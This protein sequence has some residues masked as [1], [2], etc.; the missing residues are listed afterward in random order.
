MFAFIII[1]S[2]SLVSLGR[3]LD[4]AVATEGVGVVL[5]ENLVGGL[6]PLSVHG[7]TKTLREVSDGAENDTGSSNNTD[8]A[9]GNLLALTLGV[10]GLTGTPRTVGDVPSS[11]LLVG[12]K[13]VPGTLLSL[14]KLRDD[15]FLLLG[16]HLLPT[17][18]KVDDCRVGDGVS[19]ANIGSGSG[20]DLAGWSD[21]GS[22]HLQEKTVSINKIQYQK[23]LFFSSKPNLLLVLR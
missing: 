6:L 7:N 4:L 20:D 11:A 12:G 9:K 5:L 21:S 3:R 1:T 8:N 14:S 17:R 16:G 2:L 22:Q 13:L 15:V 18:L 23:I 10:D 19:H